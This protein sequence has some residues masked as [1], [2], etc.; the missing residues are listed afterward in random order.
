[1]IATGLMV[2]ESLLSISMKDCRKMLSLDQ[3]LKLASITS[4]ISQGKFFFYKLTPYTEI[5]NFTVGIF[6]SLK[7]KAFRSIL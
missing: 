3:I 4:V 1:M 7:N 2:L 5:L 6:K